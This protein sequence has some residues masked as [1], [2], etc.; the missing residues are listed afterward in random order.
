MMIAS[1]FL[2]ILG[3]IALA[4]VPAVPAHASKA[5]DTIRMPA[6]QVLPDIDPYFNNELLGTVLGINV[7]DSLIFRDPATGEF[8]GQLA[9]AWRVIDDTTVEFDLRKDVKFHNGQPFTADDV[10]YTINFIA[11]PASGVTNQRNVSWLKNA[12]K[13]D[14]YKVRIHFKAP[15]PPFMDYFALPIIIHPHEYYAKE[16]RKGQNVKPVG[17]GPYRITR[18]EPGKIIVL[19]RN[20]DYYP[21]TVKSNAK[22]GKVEI[23]FVPD[24]QTQVANLMTGGADLLTTPIPRDMTDNVALNPMLQVAGV[25]TMRLNFLQFNVLDTTASPALKDVRVRKAIMHA[26]DREALAKTTMGQGYTLPKVLC[27]RDQFGCIDKDVAGYEYSPQKAKDLLKEAGFANGVDVVMNAFTSRESAEIMQGYLGK[28]GIRA[29]IVYEQYPAVREKQRKGTSGMTLAS[30]G[31]YSVNDVSAILPV[32]FGNEGDDTARD[33]EVADLINRAGAV[34][35]QSARAV[36]YAKAL[37]LISERALAMPLYSVG[38]NYPANK[39]LNMGRQTSDRMM[40][41]EMSWR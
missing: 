7:W 8:R 22:V 28:V 32:Y 16:G 9:T 13:L 21:G 11:D 18:Y 34:M 41:W 37:Q 14:P 2:A 23:T 4:A 30:W 12:E 3:C 20:R 15:F 35:D 1:R 19:E 10:V 25:P 38:R 17:S 26:I 6:D 29:N 27:Y 36:D 24:I 39:E 33:K 31:S 5:D 40:F